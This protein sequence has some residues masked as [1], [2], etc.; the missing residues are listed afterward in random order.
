MSAAHSDIDLE[1]LARPGD[2]IERP[3]K[4][5]WRILLPVGILV[6]FGAVLGSSLLEAFASEVEV[7]FVR[8]RR[9]ATGA[10]SSATAS[11]VVLQAAGWVEPDPS[12]EHVPALASGFVHEVLVEESD[13][14]EV[15][16][17]VARLVP[18]DARIE[19]AGASAE[20]ERRQESHDRLVALLAIEQE[21]FDEALEV[22]EAVT[23]AAARLEG[24]S[25][26]SSA[27]AAAIVQG[28]AAV[29]VAGAELEVQREL[30]AEGGTG[31]WEVELAEA[32]LEQARGMLSG[33]QAK[34]ALAAAEQQAAR[35][36]PGP[37]ERERELRLVD[38]V[39]LESARVAVARAATELA[40]ATTARE[41]AELRS[42]RMA[43]ISPV[44]GVVLERLVAPGDHLSEHLRT[45]V[46]V[47]D[48]SSLRVR[49]DV[50]QADIAGVGAG[51]RAEV[52]TEAR[53]DRPYAAH[54]LRIV[55]LSDIQKVTLEV[56][57]RV[58]EPDELIRPDMLCQVRFLG[59]SDEPGGA[60]SSA[61]GEVLLVPASLVEGGA[62]W[63]LSSDGR[64]A[65][66]R[67]VTTG[68]EQREEGV[69]WLRVTAGLNLSDKLL[70]QRTGE[71]TEGVRVRQREE[72]R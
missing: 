53:P 50:P 67:R 43:V 3:R 39:H 54:V 24:A 41:T 45:I 70:V 10:A 20:E 15:G 68:G 25:S 35:V 51:G 66:R 19:L 34:A 49:V 22:T 11:H 13:T 4:S 71:L 57:V 72:E 44:E 55:Q 17:V 58:D 1:R 23:V 7:D 60:G 32:S 9:E 30:L 27:S 64:S 47:Y 28:E 38:R 56:Q 48:P 61:P 36:R 16:Q 42:T 65:T 62:V 21:R 29:R 26:A 6:I 37:A 46:S 59:R 8:P 2:G 63:V 33:L 18:D 69:S 40:T 52:L 12:P 14:I 5:V 31:A